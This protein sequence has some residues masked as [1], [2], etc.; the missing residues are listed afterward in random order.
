MILA[1]RQEFSHGKVKTSVKPMKAK[2]CHETEIPRVAVKYLQLCSGCMGLPVHVFSKSLCK[3][4]S[5]RKYEEK[6]PHETNRDLLQS[7]V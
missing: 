5:P 1:L 4:E 2:K 7:T 6:G 3:M